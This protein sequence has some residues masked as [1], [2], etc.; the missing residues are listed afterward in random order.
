MENTILVVEDLSE[1]HMLIQMSLGYKYKIDFAATVGRARDLLKSNTYEL[2]LL[3][4]LLPDGSGLDLCREIHLSPQHQNTPIIFLTAKN[5]TSDKVLGFSIGV[6]D[7]IV[8]PFDPSELAA[9]VDLRIMKSQKKKQTAE[10]F[11]KR[12]MRF[13]LSGFRLYLEDSLNEKKIDVTP[14]EFKI[15]L[16]LAQNSNRVFSRQQILDSVWGHDVY[17]DDRSI[18]RHISS[19]RKKIEPYQK[20]IKTV[21][22]IG[23]EFKEA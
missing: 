9:R 19:I 22:G 12:P 15:L 16:K 1:Y 6:D 11:K 7:Y 5:S 17:I 23:Y 18:D 4:V 14:I 13:E 20:M 2:I 8:K 21:S 10:N 3:D